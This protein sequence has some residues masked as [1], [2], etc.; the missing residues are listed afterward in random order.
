M[1]LPF[2]SKVI[3]TKMI[4]SR[5]NAFLGISGIIEKYDNH[6]RKYG[7]FLLIEKLKMIKKGSLYFYGDLYRRFHVLLFN[8]KNKKLNI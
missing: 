5:K 8:E 4:F 6:P 2:C 3:K 1:M 7:I